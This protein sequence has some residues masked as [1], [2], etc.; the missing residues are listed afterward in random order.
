[1]KLA[2]RQ[3]EILGILLIFLS[4]MSVIS[5]FGHNYTDTLVQ[6]TTEFKI[7]NPLGIV[8]AFFSFY[9]FYGFGYPSITIP[10][11]IGIV[12]LDLF[13]NK[14]NVLQPCYAILFYSHTSYLL[15]QWLL[16]VLIYFHKFVSH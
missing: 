4:I 15:F 9:L 13:R 1:M 8:G 16:L 5:L 7:N 14:D 11:I 10:I 3:K 12:G 6:N 2:K